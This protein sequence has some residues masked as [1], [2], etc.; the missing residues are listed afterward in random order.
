MT[1]LEP[2]EAAL[3]DAWAAR[4][5][6]TDALD[7]AEEAL[8]ELRDLEQTGTVDPSFSPSNPFRPN[9]AA[10]LAFP[11]LLEGGRRRDLASVLAGLVTL[12][13]YAKD[14]DEVEPADYDKRLLLVAQRLEAEHGYQRVRKGRGLD[15]YLRV[16]P[17]R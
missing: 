12:H 3:L 14:S 1:R 13:P 8:V 6:L 9:S 4:D 5:A 10:H 17:P 15:G 2:L 16:D 11:L 7:R